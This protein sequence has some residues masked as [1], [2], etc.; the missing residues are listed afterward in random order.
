MSF[1]PPDRF[2]ILIVQHCM[3]FAYYS[4]QKIVYLLPEC[5]A[6]RLVVHVWLVLVHPPQPGDGLAVH[7]LEHALRKKDQSNSSKL[8][9]WSSNIQGVQFFK[10]EE[11][12]FQDTF[13]RL[14]HLM[15]LGQHSGSCG[16]T[17]EKLSN[18]FKYQS[19]NKPEFTSITITSNTKTFCHTWQASQVDWFS[20]KTTLSVAADFT[21]GSN[22]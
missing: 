6:H 13:S 20:A 12:S 1:P 11:L 21:Q 17:W 7:Q 19:I 10:V 3:Q 8:K 16:E 4:S 9:S 2:N 22:G 18:I 14:L 5:P 15:N